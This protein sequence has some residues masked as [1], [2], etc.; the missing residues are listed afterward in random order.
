[1][2]PLI[3]QLEYIISFLSE[4]AR[5]KKEFEKHDLA[6]PRAKHPEIEV[7]SSKKGKPPVHT[8][9]TRGARID[10]IGRDTDAELT[11]GDRV[12]QTGSPGSEGERRERRDQVKRI[13][14]GKGDNW[15]GS[16]I[17]SGN[18]MNKASRRAR[19]REMDPGRGLRTVARAATR[20]GL[21]KR[22]ESGWERKPRG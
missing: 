19:A 16:A 14:R 22:S 7:T 20:K 11:G 15:I 9:G 6:I 8:L 13:R 3:E 10:P 18:Q 1:M 5:W 12:H 2:S 21:R 17:R 4:R